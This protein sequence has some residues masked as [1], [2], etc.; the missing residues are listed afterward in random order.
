MVGYVLQTQLGQAVGGG[1]LFVWCVI[2]SLVFCRSFS[3]QLSA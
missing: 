3:V 1:Y 2:L